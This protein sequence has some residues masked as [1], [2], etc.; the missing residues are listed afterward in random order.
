MNGDST[1]ISGVSRRDVLKGTTALTGAAMA[2]AFPAPAIAQNKAI[3]VLTLSQGIFGQP[4]VD[5][6]AGIHQADRHQGQHDH[7]GLQ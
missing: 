7:D 2:G 1:K 6:G 4:F 5:S 3:S